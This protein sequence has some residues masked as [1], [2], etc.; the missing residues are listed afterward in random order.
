MWKERGKG[1][2]PDD[3]FGLLE[4]DYVKAEECLKS[5]VIAAKA[6]LEVR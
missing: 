1:V 4:S 2:H 5:I 6:D 3:W